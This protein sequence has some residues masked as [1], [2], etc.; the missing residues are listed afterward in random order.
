[1]PHAWKRLLARRIMRFLRHYAEAE[2]MPERRERLRRTGVCLGE[3]VV[4][5]DTTLDAVYPWLIS[6]GDDCTITGAQILAHDDSTILFLKQR[7]IAPVTIGNRVFIGR[8]SI[9]L[10]GVTIGSDVIVGAGAIVTHDVPD[11]VVVAGNPAKRIGTVADLCARRLSAGRLLPHRFPSNLV[12]ED[13]DARVQEI[14]H[15][16]VDA[17]FEPACRNRAEPMSTRND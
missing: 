8:G 5:Y 10:P 11:G 13:V 2:T 12:T 3:G 14:A 17:R 9:V 15:R 4:I 7:L 16:W 6:I 1:M